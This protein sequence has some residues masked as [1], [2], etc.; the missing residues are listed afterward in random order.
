MGQQ[1]ALQVLD[2]GG[3]V[4]PN[5]TVV[6]TARVW[7]YSNV[8]V[9]DYPT[10][11]PTQLNGSASVAITLY[12]QSNQTPFGQVP[13]V[14]NSTSG[15]F[16]WSG[17][18]A[19]QFERGVWRANFYVTSGTAVASFPQRPVFEVANDPSPSTLNPPQPSG[20]VTIVVVLSTQS[21]YSVSNGFLN[22]FIEAYAGASSSTVLNLPAATG[23][24]NQITV[25]KMDANNQNIVVTAN[26]TD[27]I[28]GSQTSLIGVQ[29][30]TLSYI[31][32]AAGVW[33]RF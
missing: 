14:Y 3:V 1:L 7:D 15:N 29:Y 9:T 13:M 27:L 30:A 23:S 33:L 8:L 16:V 5:S 11:S 17:L 31:D 19:S 25:K 22:Q 26:G 21:P 28:D 32:A 4:S 10:G 18:I 6:V 2:D 12:T 20:V 24:G